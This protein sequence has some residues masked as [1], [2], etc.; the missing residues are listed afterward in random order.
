MSAADAILQMRKSGLTDEQ[1]SAIAAYVEAEHPDLTQLAT[2][3]DVAELR[4]SLAEVKA[5][6]LKW[7]VGIGVVQLTGI[8]GLAVV[9]A[10]A[11]PGGH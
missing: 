3:T 7:V 11:V 5:D 6:L 1:V 2:K 9:L 4:T 10:R 8:V